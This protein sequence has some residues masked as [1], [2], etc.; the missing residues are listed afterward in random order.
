ME[1]TK[2]H[3]EDLDLGENLNNLMVTV[4]RCAEEV[5]EHVT[6]TLAKNNVRI[7]ENF[8]EKIGIPKCLKTWYRAFTFS[9]YHPE[10]PFS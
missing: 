2:T 3:V 7:I 1:R 6:C 4:I 5:S 10:H 8:T 9:S